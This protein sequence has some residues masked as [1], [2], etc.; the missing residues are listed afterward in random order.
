MELFEQNYTVQSI[1]QAIGYEPKRISDWT[2]RGLIAGTG[3]G[4]SK[5][6]AR[7]YS[8]VQ[9]M[10]I[11]TA[12]SAMDKLSY[13]PAQAFELAGHFAS[14]AADGRKPGLPFH[15]RLGTTYLIACDGVVSV[16]LSE[17]GTIKPI[18]SEAMAI[19]ALNVTAVFAKVAAALGYDAGKVLNEAYPE[20][21]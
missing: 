14:V 17:D 20:Y 8:F 6:R 2:N 1:G 9:L 19:T 16:Q 7:T 13:Q 15:P 11:A 5:G 4:G 18:N 10:Q 12:T 3:G 21:A